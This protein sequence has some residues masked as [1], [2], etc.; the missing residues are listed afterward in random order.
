M[1]IGNKTVE[2]KHLVV[3]NRRINSAGKILAT[4]FFKCNLENFRSCGSLLLFC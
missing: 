3:E 4:L 1:N 2:L